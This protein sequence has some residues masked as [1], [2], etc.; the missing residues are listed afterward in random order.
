M[1]RKRASKSS[2]QGVNKRRRTDH[3]LLQQYYAN[4]S[5]LRQYLVSKL[6]KTSKKR[7]RRLL[8]YGSGSADDTPT[9]DL[10]VASLLD[11]VIVGSFKWI[12]REPSEDVLSEISVFTQQLTES[13]VVISPTQGAFK[14]SEVGWRSHLRITL[15]L[16]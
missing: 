14:Q 16:P 8:H 15:P 7:R 9:A 11:G 5:S 1:K 13:T 2:H 4:I 12:Q 3:P 6:P 10:R